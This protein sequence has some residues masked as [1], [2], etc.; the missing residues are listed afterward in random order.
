MSGK[1]KLP[2]LIIDNTGI[3]SRYTSPRGGGGRAPFPRP[4]RGRRSHASKLIDELSSIMDDE[5]G[6]INAQKDNNTN[7]QFGIYLSFESDPYFGLKFE[8]L[9]LSRSKIELCNVKIENEITI[10]TV[11]VPDGKLEQFLKKIIRYRDE[12]R[13]NKRGETK[14]KEQDLIESIASIKKAALKELFTDDVSLFPKSGEVWWEVWLRREGSHD[15]V[16]LLR[17]HA[18]QHNMLISNEKINFSDRTVVLAYGDADSI[19]ESITLLGIIAEIR[20]AKDTADFYTSMDN[21]E[22]GQWTQ[23]LSNRLQPP[24]ISAAAV[25]VLD[26]GLNYA[27]PF[28]TYV[29][30]EDSVFSYDEP[31]WGTHDTHGHGTMMAGLAVYG[32]LTP[33]LT[34]SDDVYAPHFL[35][36]VK[37][38]PHPGGGSGD[39]KLYG[40]V[41]RESI[42]R[43][44]TYYPNRQRT[45][46][47][48][49]S[50]PD[51]RDFGRPSAWSAAL[52]SIS[53]GYEDDT[54]RLIVVAGGNT[55]DDGWGSYPDSN[56]TDQVHD[57]AQAW[58]VITVGGYTEKTA[59]AAAD[60]L[61]WEA[62]APHGDLA[63]TS[64]TSMEWISG[65]WPIKPDVVMEAGNLKKSKVDGSVDY[66]DSLQ[67]LSTNNQFS[68]GKAVIPCGDTS[69]AAALAARLA[70]MVQSQYP[71]LWPETIRA[72]IVHSASWTEAMKSR[73]LNPRKSSQKVADYKKL[74]RYCGY[75]VPDSEALF[76]SAEDALTLIVEDSLQPFFMEDGKDKTC[77]I[78]HHLLPWPTDVLEDLGEAQVEM[79]VTLSYF[80]EPKPGNR[81]WSGKYLYA[82]HGL[83]FEVRRSL[84]SAAA[85]R[86]RINKFA[87]E[88][89][90][91]SSSVDDSNWLLGSTLRTVGSVHSDTWV[92]TAS[93]LA[94][95]ADIAVFP[96][97]GW[98]KN[99]KEMLEKQARYSLVVTIKTPETDIYTTIANLIG[100]PVAID[101]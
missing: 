8:S 60:F 62:Q 85:F 51:D 47:L 29:T 28:L 41:T 68:L 25:C 100:V 89:G 34:S 99:N 6:I 65:P 93:E 87:Q 67:L 39:K 55:D 88:A 97:T 95:K 54:R 45:Y 18:S 49:V 11:F 86:K 73:F 84:E 38:L 90:Y 19:S 36:S 16:E 33:H 98:W 42:S 1:Q 78:K 50:A 56:L 61:A 69:A 4:E 52:D 75:G 82:S 22:Q 91:A 26:T 21:I 71:N 5:E 66:S 24:P 30:N 35:E 17:E 63:P 23:D 37:V 79:K 83:R 44:E 57:P 7:A 94:Q 31:N 15:H 77:E 46:C 43:V 12:N 32:D 20:L 2:H 76:W 48:A 92:G 53:S 72:M 58:N 9:G 40:S 27:H 59:L 64:C 3:A 70:T 10:A 96:V 74:I 81:G 101:T 13:T 80:I 14:P